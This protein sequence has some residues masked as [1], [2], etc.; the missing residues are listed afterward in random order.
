MSD[1]IFADMVQETS[2]TNG[3]GKFILSGAT[4]GHRP[5]ASVV[6]TDQNFQYAIHGLTHE[7]EW[8]IG[9]GSLDQDGALLRSVLTSSENNQPV[10]FSEGIKSVS[11]IVAADWYAAQDAG[12]GEVAEHT[13]AIE[14]V[15]GL[16]DLLAQ[17][18]PLGDYA[19]QDHDHDY[20]PRNAQ[21]NWVIASGNVGVG[22][23]SPPE[24]MSISGLIT[25]GFGARTTTGVKDWND[26]SNA[27]SGQGA[28]L[29]NQ[30]AANRPLQSGFFHPFSFEY[31][32]K[33]GAGNLTQFAIPYQ[34]GRSVH[35]R[36]RFGGN[37][38]Q[39]R[40]ILMENQSHQFLPNSDGLASLGSSSN[41]FNVLYASNGVQ[42]T[43]DA[44]DKAWR[45]ALSDT[46]YQ[47]GLEILE[48][49]G[50]FQW[51]AA[52][53]VD[54]ADNARYHFGVR[55]QN[56][57][58]IMAQHGLVGALAETDAPHSPYGFL[59]YDQWDAEYADHLN[60]DTGEVVADP[61]ADIL[62]EA[63]DRF[64]IRVDQLNSFLI[65]VLARQQTL[66]SQRL[67]QVEKLS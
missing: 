49:L 66:L 39:W 50:F 24:K 42:S 53:E 52:I 44:R 2:K 65:A 7:G 48:Q 31:A 20:W 45:G 14:A 60:P 25:G 64:G 16:P 67:A 18:Q 26:V 5:F 19:A 43:S 46:E 4:P 57:W 32:T 35:M 38:Q 1:V 47:A 56:I 55:A 29:L 9:E 3:I 8:E 36:V 33:T 40:T 58:S 11:L 23:G 30:T 6:Q 17:K 12:Q 28:S 27:R 13:H 22:L 59:C 61:D 10:D 51:N 54:G 41:R 34:D 15:T 37:W 62:Y 63:G 21:G